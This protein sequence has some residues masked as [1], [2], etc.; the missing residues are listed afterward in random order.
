MQNIPECLQ[1]VVHEIEKF[2]TQISA[3]EAKTDALNK[4]VEAIASEKQ[5]LEEKIADED[6]R[7]RK[8]IETYESEKLSLRELNIVVSDQLKE[9]ISLINELQEQNSAFK[10][11]NEALSDKNKNASSESLRLNAEEEAL[12]HQSAKLNE[13]IASLKAQ[14]LA[15]KDENSAL[16]L[17]N[18]AMHQRNLDNQNGNSSEN[19]RLL[20]EIQELKNELESY[21]AGGTDESFLKKE[22][23]RLIQRHGDITQEKMQASAAMRKAQDELKVVQLKL[24]EALQNVKKLNF[25]LNG[26]QN[27]YKNLTQEKNDLLANSK[28][29]AGQKSVL[30]DKNHN[31]DEKLQLLITEKELVV[32][33]LNQERTKSDTLTQVINQLR[34]KNSKLEDRVT[35]VSTNDTLENPIVQ[36]DVPVS[37]REVPEVKELEI[38][39]IVDDYEDDV[40]VDTQPTNNIQRSGPSFPGES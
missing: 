9:K 40:I 4:N 37:P 26:M 20:A 34:I 17:V 31:Y 19:P 15:L 13:Q 33:E 25:E 35:K 30:E 12:I 21:K 16:T 36:A 11:E 14:N 6:A 22:N 1:P 24:D 39:V 8:I 28:I 29:L 7:H 2:Q 38:D 32:Q 5:S 18:S 27:L 3:L 10:N 23:E